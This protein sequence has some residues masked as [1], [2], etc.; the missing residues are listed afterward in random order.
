MSPSTAC[1]LL[2][3]VLNERPG[4]NHSYT[5]SPARKLALR[6]GFNCV[7][8]VCSGLLFSVALPLRSCAPADSQSSCLL[9][10]PDES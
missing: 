9:W 10:A 1:Y 8:L 7:V 5:L 4:E 3:P 6:P 2:T